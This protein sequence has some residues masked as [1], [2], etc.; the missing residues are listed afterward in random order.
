[1]IIEILSNKEKEIINLLAHGLSPKEIAD[2]LYV[3]INTVKTHINNIY[4]KSCIQ[5]KSKLTIII[6]HYLK[7]IRVL[8]QNWKIKE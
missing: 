5:N 3:S 1:M 2:K 4:A 8:N 6:L 7:D